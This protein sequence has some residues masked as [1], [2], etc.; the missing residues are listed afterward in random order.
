MEGCSA[1][2]AAGFHVADALVRDS[3]Q[4]GWNDAA[5][6]RH[7]QSTNMNSVLLKSTRQALG[8]PCFRA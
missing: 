6:R 3:T 2:F 8:R 1:T 4:S 7:L 5:P